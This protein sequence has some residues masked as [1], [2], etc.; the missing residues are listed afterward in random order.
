MF[1]AQ[2]NA[3]RIPLEPCLSFNIFFLM[4]PP[5]CT[6]WSVLDGRRDLNVRLAEKSATHGGFERD[7]ACWNVDNVGIRPALQ[8]ARLCTE[9]DSL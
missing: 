6:T 3:C 4:S 2:P 9:R 7:L 5:V 8:R 1:L